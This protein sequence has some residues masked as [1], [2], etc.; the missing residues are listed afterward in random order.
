MSVPAP[1]T[2]A[3]LR[4]ETGYLGLRLRSPIILGA[5]PLAEDIGALRRIEELGAGAVVLH[6]L[7]EEQYALDRSAFQAHTETHSWNSPE[8]ASYFPAAGD[9]TFR[10]DRYFDQVR[11]AKDALGIPVIASL[12]GASAGGWLDYAVDIQNAG[13][14]ALELNIYRVPAD[15]RQ[16]ALDLELEIIQLV[17]AVRAR[18]H[19]PFAVKLSPFYTVLPQVIRSLAEHGANGAVL[20]NRFLQPDLDIENLEVLPRVQLSSPSDLLLRLRWLAILHGRHPLSLALSGGVH[21]AEDIVKGLMAGAD[22]VQV[23]SYVLRHGVEA[24]GGLVEDFTRWLEEHEIG[25]VDDIRGCLSLGRCPDP[26]A[27][28]RAH[29]MKIV[30]GWKL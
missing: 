16:S 29:Y 18:L 23:V 2:S 25:G 24:F 15:D 1:A 4:L 21:K 20:F 11:S 27:Y 28:E 7:F 13:A 3:G 5:S 9:F 12:N 22:A 14:D 17:Q 26:A 10:P 30:Q 6:S 19:I 8:A